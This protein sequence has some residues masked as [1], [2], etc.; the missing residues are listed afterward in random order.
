MSRKGFPSYISNLLG[1]EG[2]QNVAGYLE[3]K[4]ISM[5]KNIFPTQTEMN[6]DMN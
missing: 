1:T 4:R 2:I 6:I 3:A 5:L